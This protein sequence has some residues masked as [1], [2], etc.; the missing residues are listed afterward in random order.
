M[1][2]LNQP[3]LRANAKQVP[4]EKHL[5]QYDRIQ[6]RAA[7]VQAVLVLNLLPD[8]TEVDVLVNLAEQVVRSYQ[9]LDVNGL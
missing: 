1:D 9:L 6:R 4:D 3:A 7:V 8:E 2:L 5:E